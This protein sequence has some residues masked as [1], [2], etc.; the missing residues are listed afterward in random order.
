MRSTPSLVWLLCSFVAAAP[1]EGLAF[2]VPGAPS[3]AVI[4]SSHIGAHE[5]A[6]GAGVIV[7]IR[8]HVLRVL[9]ARHV[10][11]R[12]DVTVWLERRPYPAEIVRTFARRDLAVVDVLVPTS[13]E[14]HVV[15]A[16]AGGSIAAGQAIVVW[17]EN[18]AGPEPKTGSVVAP[19]W[20]APDPAFG[21]PLVSIA[22]RTCA[23]GDSG[24]G[25]FDAE[26]R[27]LGILVARFLRADGT[28]IAMVAEPIEP[29]LYATE[30]RVAAKT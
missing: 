11:E 30:E 17:G 14:S 6:I 27:L 20:S 3:S 5:D 10:A 28:T 4:V 21:V 9:T 8:P 25:V 29:S 7:A 24:G 16:S 26:G 18:D 12:G 2:D 23:R 1:S 13:V 15:A 19:S 22:C